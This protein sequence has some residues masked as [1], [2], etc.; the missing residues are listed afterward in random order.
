MIHDGAVF[1]YLVYNMGPEWC[2]QWDDPEFIEKYYASLKHS[3][4]QTQKTSWELAQ[5]LWQQLP[6]VEIKTDK[7]KDYR[8]KSDAKD[9]VYFINM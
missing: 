4:L 3:S 1:I 5:N 6:A 2:Y 7:D 8:K 9:A